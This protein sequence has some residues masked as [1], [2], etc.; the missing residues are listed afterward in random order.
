MSSPS[1]TKQVQVEVF[2]PRSLF[3]R[4]GYEFESSFQ[5]YKQ[6]LNEDTY[7]PS[8]RDVKLSKYFVSVQTYI[9][10]MAAITFFT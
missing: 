6:N 5:L 4:E 7:F 2:I 3:F 9:F 1:K 10:L 8:T